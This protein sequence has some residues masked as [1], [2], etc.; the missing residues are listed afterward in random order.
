MSI[1]VKNRNTLAKVVIYKSPV[2]KKQIIR[3]ENI[4]KGTSTDVL[5]HSVL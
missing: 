1:K 5:R 2:S 3:F 4:Q